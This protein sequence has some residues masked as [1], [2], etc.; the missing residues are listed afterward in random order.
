MRKKQFKTESKKM[1][2][3]MIHSIYTHDEIFLRELIS[4]ASDAIDKRSFRALTDESARLADGEEYQIHISTDSDARTLTITDNGCGMTEQELEENLGTIARSGSLDFKREN[5]E[6]ESAAELIGQFGVGF[7]AAFMVSDNVTVKSRAIGEETGHIWQSEGTNGYSIGECDVPAIGSEITLHIKDDTESDHYGRFLE[8]YVIRQ[9]VKKYSD[10]I[11]YPIRME[12]E[13][14]KPKEGTGSDEKAPEYETVIETETFNSM[15]PIWHRNPHDVS[16]EEYN[17]FYR[18]KFFGFDTPARVIHSHVEGTVEYETLLYIP[19]QPPFDYY[20][21]DFEKGL[22]LYSNGVMIMEKCPDLLP[23]YFGFVRGLVDSS[24]F[25]LNI[26]RE[27]LQHD[28]QLRLIAKTLEKKIKNELAKMMASDRERYE[29]FYKSFGLS[30]KYGVYS[31]YGAHRDVLE[32]LLLFYSTNEKKYVSLKEY[33][34]RMPESQKDIYYACGDSVDAC[35]ML[36][37][38]AA[39]TEKGYEVLLLTDDVDE[40]ALKVLAQYDDKK[41][42]NVCAE[43]LDIATEEEKEAVTAENE[44]EKELLDFLKESIGD[45]VSAV[46]FTNALHEHPVCLSSEGGLSA[47]MEKVL[48]KMPGSEGNV[49]KAALVLEIN[50]DHPVAAALKKAYAENH[51]E[52]ARCAKILYAQARLISGLGVA[53]PTEF[54]RLVCEMMAEKIG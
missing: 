1:L 45:D 54:S 39:V 32:D 2:D 34:A 46:R 13:K 47:E 44:K 23:D 15:T 22:Q 52:A 26:S 36:P 18:E 51:D 29:K 35:A 27:T 10:Y 11:R 6:N 41:F 24:D 42:T 8:S 50:M 14:H 9:L 53:D 12:V 21:K 48:K 16:E 37:Q 17:T 28:H 20:S 30:L 7:Y 19:E 43:G 5:A 33:V 25:T 40:F 49:P 3:M 38:T 31:E 4:N